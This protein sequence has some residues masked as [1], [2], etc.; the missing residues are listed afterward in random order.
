MLGC[1]IRLIKKLLAYGFLDNLTS[2]L[3]PRTMLSNF[4]F[5]NLRYDRC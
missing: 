2:T 1:G 4:V 5:G 3:M